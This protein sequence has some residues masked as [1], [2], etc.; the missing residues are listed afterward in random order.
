MTENAYWT[1]TR[2]IFTETD[3]DTFKLW[4]SVQSVP[5]YA[6]YQFEEYYGQDVAQLIFRLKDKI[7]REKWLTALK[8]PFLGHTEQSYA[9]VKKQLVLEKDVV[10]TSP[11][12]LKS[13]H[14]VL[15]Y[16][17]NSKNDLMSFDQ[18]VE[19][20]PGIGETCRLINDLGYKGNYYLYDLPEVLNVSMFYNKAYENVKGINHYSEVDPNKK[21]LFIGTWSIS[22]APPS[23]RDEIFN[24]FKTADYLIIYQKNAFEYSNEP[25][26]MLKFPQIINKN[27]KIIDIP[28]L[29]SIAGGNRYLFVE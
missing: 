23:Y 25:Y 5:I 24:Y 27:V 17:E 29:Q 22:E 11:W 16:I 26:F 21:T 20:G 2:K 7:D 9:A 1:E 10:E 18:I 6:F 15:M 4:K 13:A 8:E 3:Y 19:F 12:A 28:W 14:H